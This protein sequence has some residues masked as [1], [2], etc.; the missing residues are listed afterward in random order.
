MFSMVLKKMGD[1]FSWARI[2]EKTI[3][4]KV[5]FW[6]KS[7][8]KSL[9]RRY[10]AKF[11]KSVPEHLKVCHIW[12]VKKMFSYISYSHNAIVFLSNEYL[13]MYSR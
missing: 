1:H 5:H 8:I 10:Q 3:F 2:I 6:I 12:L 9:V 4:K 7:G 13:P 11:S